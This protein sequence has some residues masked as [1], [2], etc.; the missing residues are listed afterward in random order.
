MTNIGSSP[1]TSVKMNLRDPIDFVG[2]INELEGILEALSP[3][4]RAWIISLT[5]VGGIGKSEL[6]IKAAHMVVER[7]LFTSVV[8]ITAKDSW[9]TY[10][11]IKTEYSFVSLD[12]LLNTITEVLELHPQPLEM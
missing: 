10:E 12:D 2:R 3:S 7:K 9:L 4:T 1:D 6:A 5:G 11:G 8:W